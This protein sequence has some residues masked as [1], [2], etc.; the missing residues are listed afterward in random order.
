MSGKRQRKPIEPRVWLPPKRRDARWSREFPAGTP[1]QTRFWAWIEK[2]PQTGCWNWTA[3]KTPRG[4]GLLKLEKSAG[5]KLVMTH[6]LSYE[7]H[8]GPIPEG[9]VIDHLCENIACCNPD[10]L[11]VTTQR[12]NVLRGIG[13]PAQNARKT[14]CKRGHPLP[15]N[16]KCKPCR[17]IRARELRERRRL[18]S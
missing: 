4:Y 5:G 12:N 1:W 16:R 18:A 9:L 8:K 17:Q 6:R 10:H 7:M 11:R 13:A 2:D 3:Y 15:E 14:H